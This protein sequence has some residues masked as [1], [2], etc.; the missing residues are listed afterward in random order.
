[1]STLKTINLKHPDGTANT[2]QMNSSSDLIINGAGSGNVGIGTTSPAGRLS[3][4]APTGNGTLDF[5]TGSITPDSLRIQSGGSVTN[6]LEYRGYL[7]HA[8]IVDT[9]E[10]MRINS[11]GNVGIGYTTPSEKLGVNGFLGVVGTHTSPPSA[12][13]SIS[14][15]DQNNAMGFFNNSTERMRINSSGYVG[16]GNNDPDQRLVIGDNST[17]NTVKIEGSDANL[18]ATLKFLHHGGGSRTGVTPEWNI[19][20]A[21]NETNF[22][23]GV[24]S[25]GAVGGLAF[26]NN[27][28]GGSNVDA[29]RLKDNGDAVFGYRVT[30]PNQPSFSAY[31]NTG[32]SN[33]GQLVVFPS[34]RH[35]VGGHYSTSTGRF[36]AP[37]DGLYQF[38]FTSIGNDS[39]DTYRMYL[40]LNGSVIG[41][42]H[43]RLD[44]KDSGTT[45]Y[46]TNGMYTYSLLLNT[47]D[48]VQIYV[49]SDGGTAW[50][51]SGGTNNTYWQFHGYLIG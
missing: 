43:L 33:G 39:N 23:V 22:G 35:N 21:S 2:I 7:G 9:T 20:R 24:T 37:V 26:W 51:G 30:K 31:G 1:M 5:V 6:W 48:Y 46:C 17:Y 13:P 25:G 16:I 41:D 32:I 42:V 49:I 14:R 36:T 15:V 3:L 18:A 45:E 11:S 38:M 27:T 47:N 28:P 19:A 40:Y 29:V 50:Y 44:N 12:N 4:T 34:I 8:W 10:A